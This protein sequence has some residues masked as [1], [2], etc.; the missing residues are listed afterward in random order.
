MGLGADLETL[1]KTLKIVKVSKNLKKRGF[2]SKNLKKGEQNLKK[3]LRILKTSSKWCELAFS[4]IIPRK[5]YLGLAKKPVTFF[6]VV[7]HL[8]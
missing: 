1:K 8:Q 3:F 6:V 4:Q 5:V 7:G 2:S